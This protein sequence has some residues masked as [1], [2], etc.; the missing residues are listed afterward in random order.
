MGWNAFKEILLKPL[1]AA[2]FLLTH[3]ALAF[4]VIIS[5]YGVERLI[6]HLWEA[7]RLLI[8]RLPLRYFF[9]VIDI[10]VLTMFGI[11]GIIAAYR[12]F[13]D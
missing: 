4:L 5:I 13:E 2:A 12:A 10:G 6:A 9:D 3:T 11:R 1:R 8:D 7:D